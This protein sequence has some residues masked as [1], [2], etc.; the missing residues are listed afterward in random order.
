MLVFGGGRR[1]GGGRG[2]ARARGEGEGLLDEGVRVVES[3]FPLLFLLGG[4]GG[5]GG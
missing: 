5:L 1:R 3:L 2:R 4:R